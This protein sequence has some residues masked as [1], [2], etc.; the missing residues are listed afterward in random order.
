MID[1]KTVE[2]STPAAPCVIQQAAS[3]RAINNPER[4][5]S[6]RVAGTARASHI[7]I[8]ILDVAI[9]SVRESLTGEG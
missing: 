5:G 6:R 3:Q 4:C 9:C 7:G 8:F 2:S 1:T